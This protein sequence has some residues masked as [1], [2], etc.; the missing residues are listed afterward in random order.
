MADQRT[1]NIA[2]A[3]ATL[4]V[5]PEASFGLVTFALVSPDAPSGEL[6]LRTT[7]DL[8]PRHARLLGQALT[9][10]ADVLERQTASAP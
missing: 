5:K 2:T 8:Q 7:L 6:G 3:T 9:R 1:I 10:A 4:R